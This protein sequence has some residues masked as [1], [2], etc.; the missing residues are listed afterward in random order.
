MAH[1]RS[2]VKGANRTPL[3]RAA[4]PPVPGTESGRFARHRR[5]APFF[6]GVKGA[7][8]VRMGGSGDKKGIANV[9]TMSSAEPTRR[10]FLYIA[11]GAVAAVGTAA[12]LVPL[13][14]QM[15]PDAATVVAGLP[16][17]IDLAP[18]AAGQIVKVFWRSQPIYISHRT[19]KE[20]DE[21]RA[22]DPNSL[23]DPETD[24][25]RVK[26][27][28][29][30]WLVVVGICTHLGCIPVAH[31][32]DYDGWFCHCHGS[33]YDSSGRIRKGPAPLNLPVPPYLFLSDSKIR[34]GETETAHT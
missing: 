29:D 24:E 4:W 17:E 1:L 18:I 25:A 33:Q 6:L 15:N 22:V 11:T 2:P 31:D 16:V 14:T 13:I 7:T 26:A 9:T 5:V 27:G 8:A 32:G 21:A 34:I 12:A 3:G 23:K 10:D 19:Q 28:R 30:Q 20:I